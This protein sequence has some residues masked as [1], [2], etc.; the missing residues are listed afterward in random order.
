M[1]EARSYHVVGHFPTLHYLKRRSVCGPSGEAVEDAE[2]HAE[3]QRRNQS[4]AAIDASLEAAREQLAN[5]RKAGEKEV[6]ETNVV[7]LQVRGD[8]CGWIGTACQEDISLAIWPNCCGPLS[9]HMQACSG[10]AVR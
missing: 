3:L 1:D 7:I 6:W 5:P 2:L 9:F 8:C 4:I 10:L